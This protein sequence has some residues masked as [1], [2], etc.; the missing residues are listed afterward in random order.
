[1]RELESCVEYIAQVNIEAAERLHLAAEAAFEHLAEMPG[2]GRAYPCDAA[3]L[4]GLR[5]WNV[6]GFSNYLVFYLVF[7]DHIDI[8]RFLHGARDISAELDS[9][10]TE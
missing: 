7:D 6:T 3:R 1:M 4:Q 2:I 5:K 10:E 8:V 9:T